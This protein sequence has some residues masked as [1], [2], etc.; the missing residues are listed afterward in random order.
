MS[1]ALKRK[2]EI[3]DEIKRLCMERYKNPGD[4]TEFV[5]NLK[6]L[7]VAR[8]CYDVLSN[9]LIFYNDESLI[10]HFVVEDIDP[11]IERKSFTIGNVLNVKQL[12][13]AIDHFDN[14]QLSVFEFH[15][16]VAASGIVYVSVFLNQHKIYYIGQDGNHFIELFDH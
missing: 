3:Q 13:K 16:E 14:H 8:Q 15:Q 1:H 12:Q 4:F 10:C 5:E 6:S 2:T 11:E 9:N 7:G